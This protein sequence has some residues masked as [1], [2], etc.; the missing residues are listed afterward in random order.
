[1]AL[2]SRQ[3][4]TSIAPPRQRPRISVE[5]SWIRTS[6]RFGTSSE[7]TKAKRSRKPL[8]HHE[9]PPRYVRQ[10]TDEERSH[11]Y[12]TT[13]GV[14]RELMLSGPRWNTINNRWPS[15]PLWLRYRHCRRA[16]GGYKVGK[17]DR[18]FPSGL[19]WPWTTERTPCTAVQ[20]E[21][22]AP[23]ELVNHGLLCPGFP[24][25][26]SRCS[27]SSAPTPSGNTPRRIRRPVSRSLFRARRRSHL[28]IRCA[29]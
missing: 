11:F 21:N 1:M 25:P 20:L 13:S 15:F 3:Q 5:G 27:C 23:T 28:R 16:E 7:N 18:A 9:P 12:H 14:P 2:T 8:A 22:V 24:T 26:S 19:R 4:S 29:S 10:F 6:V 17:P